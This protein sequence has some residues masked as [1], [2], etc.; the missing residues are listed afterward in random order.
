VYEINLATDKDKFI[1]WI[2]LQ[3][4]VSLIEDTK[5]GVR[6]K[7]GGSTEIEIAQ[8]LRRFVMEGFQITEFRKQ[9][10][11]LEDAFIELVTRN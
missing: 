11:R 4:N 9:E 3:P 10:R 5:K 8:L 7:I 1:E 2:A 6:I